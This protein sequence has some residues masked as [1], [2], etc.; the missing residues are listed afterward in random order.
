MEYKKIINLLDNKPSQSTKF[1]TK[2]WPQVNDEAQ[3]TYDEVNQVRFK[4]SMLRSSLC[5]YS[6]AYTLVKGTVTVENTA[7]ADATANNADKKVIFNNYAPFIKCISII[8]N[9]QV[10]DAQDID[11]VIQMYN[12]I[13]HTDSYSKTSRI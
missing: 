6:D 9:T 10:D 13:E 12:L 1:R 8:N 7:D 4:T 2:I 5:D 11:V 3:G